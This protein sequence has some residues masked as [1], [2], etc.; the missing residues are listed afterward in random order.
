MDCFVLRSYPIW[1]TMSQQFC[2]RL[3]FLQLQLLELVFTKVV[4]AII[5]QPMLENS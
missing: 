2:R 5:Y 3:E 1:G 4:H